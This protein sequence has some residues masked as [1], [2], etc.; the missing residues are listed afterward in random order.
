MIS[1]ED[2]NHKIQDSFYDLFPIFNEYEKEDFIKKIGHN[3][4]KIKKEQIFWNYFVRFAYHDPIDILNDEKH[5]IDGIT[6][7]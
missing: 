5:S 1:K 3:I 2:F 6:S 7:V 4:E